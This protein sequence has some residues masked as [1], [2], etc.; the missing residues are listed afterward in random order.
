M[1]SSARPAVPFPLPMVELPP[2]VSSKNRRC[3]QRGDRALSA[4]RL[5]NSCVQS[6]NA[7]AGHSR[8]PVVKPLSSLTGHHKST[9]DHLLKSSK[10]YVDCLGNQLPMSDDESS[11]VF[12]TPEHSCQH[13]SVSASPSTYSHSSSNAIPLIAD[14][15]ALPNSPPKAH[16]LDIL[17][18][19]L[20][21]LYS[22][23]D[24]VVTDTCLPRRYPTIPFSTPPSEYIKLVL[25]L[26]KL[27]MVNFT[28]RPRVI[29][30]LFG[31]PKSEGRIRLVVDARPA[32]HFFSRPPPVHLPT[33]DVLCSLSVPLGEKLYVAKADLTAFYHQ[34]RT[35]RWMWPFFAL[36][37][38]R[39]SDVGLQS[40]W[41][42]VM[43]YP[44]LTI[45]PMGWSHAVSLTQSGHLHVVQ[46]SGVF[47]PRA[48]IGPPENGLCTSVP[49]V[50]LYIDD[51]M[52]FGPNPRVLAKLLDRYVTLMESINLPVARS[53]LVSP[54]RSVEAIGYLFH[55]ESAGVS[56]LKLDALC[57]STRDL[58]AQPEV[59]LRDFESII[60][61][62]NWALLARRPV[63]AVFQS[64]YV[65]ADRFRDSPGISVSWWPSVRA[66]LTTVMGLAPLLF[67]RLHVRHVPHLLCTDASLLG[68][69]AVC[70][71]FTLPPIANPLSGGFC[72]AY[73]WSV[74]ISRPWSFSGAHI[75]ELEAR[76]LLLALRW[77]LYS[78]VISVLSCS[79]IRVFCDSTVVVGAVKKGRSSSFALLRI[80]RRITAHLLL[81]G[82]R[83][84]VSWVPT[85]DN[86]A[87]EPSRVFPGSVPAA[88]MCVAEDLE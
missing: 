77:L 3:R 66:E 73:S 70:S 31:T 22:S 43:I 76:G 28:Q 26:M 7:L 38:V 39:A 35:P 50:G 63:F 13:Q 87:D 47:D 25:R 48:F 2:R 62:W 16:L 23:P 36:P 15:V 64:V 40:T 75:N 44:C 69:G 37:P 53:K 88:S 52:L 81:L 86:P 41:G 34:L 49:R 10:R 54:D 51:T 32:N 12:Q 78:G 14:N 42:D 27:E 5:A 83:L 9:W 85:A 20:A 8:P 33:P 17:P 21:K 82:L 55:R 30:G 58:L 4:T 80:L 18:P 11:Y 29:N 79:T 1:S 74:I 19:H 46:S 84:D 59:C 68:V 60:G 61:K 72:D 65:L 56:P 6:L 67:V 45:L 71:E 57:R 24:G